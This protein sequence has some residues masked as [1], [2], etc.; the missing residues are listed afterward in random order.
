MDCISTN[1][2]PLSHPYP[3]KENPIGSAVSKILLYRQTH[4]QKISERSV[5]TSVSQNVRQAV[6]SSFFAHTTSNIREYK[7]N[8]SI[9]RQ[10]RGIFL[11]EKLQDILKCPFVCL[12]V[13]LSVLM[14]ETVWKK[15]EL[16]QLKINSKF[17]FV[18]IPLKIM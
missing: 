18:K 2:L 3:F 9:T 5:C 15:H 13:Y 8:E 17:F 6:I 11:L 12:S 7:K 16:L 10:N 4:K 14:L 1:I